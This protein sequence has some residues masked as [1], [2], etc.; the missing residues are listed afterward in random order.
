M[1][2]MHSLAGEGQGE[3]FS[4]SPSLRQLIDFE[5]WMDTWKNK[6]NWRDE[7]QNRLKKLAEILNIEGI[8]QH[9]KGINQL[10]LIPHRD[11]HLLPLDALFP[12]NLTIKSLPSIKVGLDRKKPTENTSLLSVE[13]PRE[14]LRFASLE[15]DSICKL[16]PKAHRIA[17]SAATQAAVKTALSKGFGIFNFT[18]HGE[19]DV[20]QPAQSALLLANEETLTLKDILELDL[21]HFNLVCLSGCKTNFTSKLGLIDEFVG[22]ASG[23]VAAG[24][25]NV[26]GSLWKV[27]DL[28]TAYL[29]TKF[30]EIWRNPDTPDVASALKAAQNWLRNATKEELDRFPIEMSQSRDVRTSF[31][32]TVE[33]KSLDDKPYQSP[34]YWAG[35]CAIGL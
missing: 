34:Y 23:F 13:N 26:I 20:N 16:Y 31:K 9:L 15:S 4:Y 27:D 10:I 19:H 12:D 7:M 3:R 28:A 2:V 22:L 11:L 33:D 29:M 17:E 1:W 21:S 18:G 25:N 5:K 32:E 24:A 35:F 8:L 14:D 6:E 30:H